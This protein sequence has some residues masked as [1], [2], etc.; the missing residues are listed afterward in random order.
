LA[1]AFED[2]SNFDYRDLFGEG[3]FIEHSNNMSFNLIISRMVSSLKLLRKPVALDKICEGY[4]EGPKL[5]FNNFLKWLESIECSLLEKDAQEFFSGYLKGN[6][7]GFAAV[8]GLQHAIELGYARLSCQYSPQVWNQVFEYNGLEAV[9][10]FKSSISHIRQQ[11]SKAG[12]KP[13][14]VAGREFLQASSRLYRAKKADVLTRMAC[15][16]SLSDVEVAAALM[17]DPTYKVEEGSVHMEHLEQALHLFK[18]RQSAAER[19]RITL[20]PDVVLRRLPKSTHTISVDD[21]PEFLVYN[22]RHIPLR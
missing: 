5:H 7:L 9:K 15:I 1:L 2:N 11:L 3:I 21:L 17:R 12:R 14:V 22:D 18:P 10:D 8:A 13:I 6:S 16:G 4:R 19:P 20:L